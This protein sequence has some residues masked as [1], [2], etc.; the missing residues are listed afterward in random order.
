MY[1]SCSVMSDSGQPYG[2]Q[3]TRLLCPWDS[4]GRNTGVDFHALFQGIFL[5][6]GLK[7]GLLHCMWT[8]YHLSHEG[9]L[10]DVGN[11]LKIPKI[12]NASAG[13]EGEECIVLL[14]GLCSL[15]QEIENVKHFYL[16]ETTYEVTFQIWHLLHQ[17]RNS[18]EAEIRHCC[19]L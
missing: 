4:P 8:L 11:N 5:T 14:R 1:V 19:V 12:R 13:R 10:Q 6:Q 3:P 15:K 2:L 18:I 9:S 17:S 7:P 16:N